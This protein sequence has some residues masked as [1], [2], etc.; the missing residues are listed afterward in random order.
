MS[1]CSL[2]LYFENEHPD[3]H[4]LIHNTC[5]D[6][7]LGVGKRMKGLTFFLPAKKDKLKTADDISRHIL[8]K[9]FN[10]ADSFI[11]VQEKGDKIYNK[12]KEVLTIKKVDDNKITINGNVEATK[13][14]KEILRATVWEITKGE[15]MP[16]D[17][18]VEI[19]RKVKGSSEHSFN[20]YKY[21][22]SVFENF[23]KSIINGNSDS[24]NIIIQAVLDIINSVS[25][26]NELN[27]IFDLTS[28]SPLT[29][30]YLVLMPFNDESIF[31]QNFVLKTKTY[32]KPIEEWYKH[33]SRS[34]KSYKVS[35]LEISKKI[36]SFKKDVCVDNLSPGEKVKKLKTFYDN[37][38]EIEGFIHNKIS[39]INR[40]W[41][42]LVRFILGSLFS[43][44]HLYIKNSDII[45]KIKLV[46]NLLTGQNK[47]NDIISFLLPDK[48]GDIAEYHKEIVL[49]GFIEFSGY[50]IKNYEH[51]NNIHIGNYIFGESEN[52]L[53][54]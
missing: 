53:C 22:Q 24:I 8:Y 16:S 33:L 34:E 40:M 18:K 27:T 15:I 30:L 41:V 35:P 21:F 19:K 46:L 4:K 52:D 50:T 37:I 9:N 5:L 11:G 51:D 17:D 20:K 47:E 10:E 49:N 44:S 42:D 13:S 39:G 3:L 28:K 23:E 25:D 7:D 38:I 43:S 32:D 45:N 31:S 29:T 12:L 6:I 14:K 36:S 26:E 2:L 48:N 54:L 1:Y